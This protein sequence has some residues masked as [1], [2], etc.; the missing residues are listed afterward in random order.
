[1][2][3]M[4]NSSCSLVT[5]SHMILE[6]LDDWQEIDTLREKLPHLYY[7]LFLGEF[8][9]LF[10]FSLIV[11]S[12]TFEGDRDQRFEE[13][14][15]WGDPVAYYHFTIR[16]ASYMD[17]S[18]FA[19]WMADRVQTQPVVQLYLDHGDF[20]NP[21]RL[22]VPDETLGGMAIMRA[23]RSYRGFSDE[24][25]TLDQL[26]DCLFAGLG[27]IGFVKGSAEGEGYLPFSTTPSGGAR[28]PYEAYVY[29]RNVIGLQPGTYHYSAKD[30][31]LAL[32]N[33]SFMP[34][35]GTVLAGQPWFDNA[36]ALVLL[37]A[38]F[39]RTMWKYP[40]P[41][42]YRVVLLEGGHIAQNI[43]LAATAHGL[44]STPTCAISDSI[45]EKLTCQTSL[46]SAAVYAI[47]LGHKSPIPTAVD[48]LQLIPNL[49]GSAHG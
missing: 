24:A 42:G 4:T 22:P 28:N 46:T 21:I 37:V 33:G 19:Q 25:L 11:Q 1:M 35:P 36:T 47:A 39:E 38:N 41:T 45:A 30:H 49:P 15:S 6:S 43:L 13:E 27:I 16:N 12:G 48:P 29:V 26:S 31:S 14:F 32:V 23:R 5:V 9:R 34:A 44:A 7:P 8:N 20:A 17:P 18:S 40:H 3:Y 2:N 10:S